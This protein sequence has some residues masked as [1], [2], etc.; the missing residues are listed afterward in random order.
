MRL[1]ENKELVNEILEY[2]DRWVSSSSL[3][4]HYLTE[5]A[6]DFSDNAT[7]FFYT[8][9][10][11]EGLKSDTSTFSYAED[12]NADNYVHSILTRNPPLSLLNTDPAALK[13]LNNQLSSFEAS[14]HGYDSFLR[15]DKNSADSL[16]AH[17]RK[18]YAIE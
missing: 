8:Q 15:L 13:K 11:D 2:Y 10:L 6:K 9:Y 18:E 17:I 16:L 5:E 1:I 14:L 7:N 3:T 4:E 12:S